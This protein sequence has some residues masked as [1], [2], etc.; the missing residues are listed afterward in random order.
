MAYESFPHAFCL[1]I[2]SRI[3]TKGIQNVTHKRYYKVASNIQFSMEFAGKPELNLYSLQKSGIVSRLTVTSKTI[4]KL[5]EKKLAE[6]LITYIFFNL[7]SRITEKCDIALS[8]CDAC[9]QVKSIIF[10]VAA[11]RCLIKSY[12]VVHSEI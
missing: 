8:Y 7:C 9:S 1:H 10:I 3:L 2:R 12:P 6:S 4:I 5:V 11:L